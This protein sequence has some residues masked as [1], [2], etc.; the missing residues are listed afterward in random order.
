M[1]YLI[2]EVNQVYIISDFIIKLL[3]QF[4]INFYVFIKKH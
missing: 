3:Y 2:C 4:F 1:K